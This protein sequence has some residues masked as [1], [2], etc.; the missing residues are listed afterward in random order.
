MAGLERAAAEMPRRQFL[1]VLGWLVAFISGI[2]ALC[3]CLKYIL[4]NVL[5]EGPSVFKIGFPDEIEPG[6]KYVEKARAY[7]FRDERGFRAITAVC[8]HLG[9]TVKWVNDPTR[10]KDQEWIKGNQGA[11]LG[12]FHC[13][14]HGSKYHSNG[15]PFA[16]P[17]PRALKW[18]KI[19]VSE[20]G[21]LVVNTKRYVD[22]AT[23]LQV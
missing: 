14:C 5:F 22:M 16:G 3:G 23:F 12:E 7:V 19:D 11:M 18:L 10:L 17:A 20:D 4:P 13:P 1:S 15:E 21:Q 8:T 6:G 9:C 2:V